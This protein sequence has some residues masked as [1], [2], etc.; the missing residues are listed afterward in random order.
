MTRR[1]CRQM[2]KFTLGLTPPQAKGNVFVQT[3]RALEGLHRRKMLILLLPPTLA[4]EGW[5][6]GG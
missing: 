6:E 4:G 2:E 3:P 1:Q 5:G